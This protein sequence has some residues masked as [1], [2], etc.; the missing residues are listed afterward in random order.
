MQFESI[1]IED[2]KLLQLVSE[3]EI[4]FSVAPN[5]GARLTSLSFLKNDK[6]HP[7]LWEVSA[8]DCKKG[9][10][11]KNEILFPFPNRIE[12]GQYEYDGIS[13][14]IPINEKSYNNAIHGMISNEKFEIKEKEINGDSASITLVHNYDGSMEYYPFPFTFEVTYSY[15]EFSKLSTTFNIYNCG[16]VTLPF[17]LGWHPYFKFGKAGLEEVELTIPESENLLLSDDRSLPTGEVI[18]FD[19]KR[20]I[21][22]DWSLDDCFRIKDSER[23]LELISEELTLR[24]EFSKEYEY[25]QLFTPES[26]GTIAIEPMTSGVNVFNNHEGIRYLNSEESFEVSFDISAN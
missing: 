21:L 12:D 19:H 18:Q 8:D 3:D 7:V 9:T 25:L 26:F 14:Q 1:V 16:R 24:M 11:S 15:S 17:G 6:R 4:L 23:S 13:Y 5:Y 22:K 2:V 20:L 10:W